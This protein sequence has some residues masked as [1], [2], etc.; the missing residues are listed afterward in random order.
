M[1]NAFA[2]NNAR[3]QPF[4]NNVS[5]GADVSATDE[6]N[7]SWTRF[8]YCWQSGSATSVD[9][10]LRNLMDNQVGNDFALD[11]IKL[12]VVPINQ[13][14]QN[15]TLCSGQSVRVGSNT[16]TTT[17]NYTDQFKGFNGCDS[18][19][20][21]NLT[22][23]PPLSKTQNI[24]ICRGESFR[25]GSNTYTQ[26]GTFTDR[27]R[28]VSNCDSVVT[29]NLTVSDFNT[30][31]QNPILCSGAT[32]R[33][34]VKNYS[35]TGSY[36]DTFRATNTCDSIILTNL[37][38]LQPYNTVQNSI[39]CPREKLV[40]GTKTYT[41]SGTYQDTLKSLIGGCDSIV[42]TNLQVKTGTSFNQRAT[43]CIGEKFAVGTKTYTTSGIYRDTIKNFT[44]CDSIVS[45][46]LT[47]L[48]TKSFVQNI[49]LTPTETVVVGTKTYSCDGRYIDTLQSVQGCDSIVYTLIRGTNNTRLFIPNIFS[50]NGD[51]NND[52]VVVYADQKCVRRVI[53]WSIYTRWGEQVFYQENFQPNDLKFGWDGT[54]K[55]RTLAPDVFSYF[56]EIEYADGSTDFVKGDITLIR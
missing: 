15:L 7:T 48:R 19:I 22:I 12:E 43:I 21:T 25:V 41:I 20:K 29:T 30:I 37:T 47:V 10:S 50:P 24:S 45:T 18:I 36:R 2:L 3:I 31:T 27:L 52:L 11:E 40:V 9:L 32:F 28:S 23:L 38:I 8:T 56:A 33:V 53:R 55:T 49:T 16:Y 6:G 5:L 51:N 39:I 17:G 44:G 54:F 42:L 13:N 1:A 35:V 34:G 46:D 4:I 26:S 14:T